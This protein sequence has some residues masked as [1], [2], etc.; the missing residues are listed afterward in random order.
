MQIN[1]RLDKQH[2]L[3]PGVLI[4]VNVGNINTGL[5]ICVQRIVGNIHIDITNSICAHL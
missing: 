1:L 5:Y 2:T 4:D 3:Q